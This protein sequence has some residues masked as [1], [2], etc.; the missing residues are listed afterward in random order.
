MYGY[1]VDFWAPQAGLVVELDGSA[2]EGRRRLDEK[3]DQVLKSHGVRTLRVRADLDIELQVDTIR[4]ALD[5]IVGN[6]SS[7]YWALNGDVPLNLAQQ[8]ST[9]GPRDLRAVVD[10]IVPESVRGEESSHGLRS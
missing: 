3:R 1:I 6:R 8:S 10:T 9:D 2:H 4:R 5:E 7:G